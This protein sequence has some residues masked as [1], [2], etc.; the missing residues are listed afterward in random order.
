MASLKYMCI[1]TVSNKLYSKKFNIFTAEEN[2]TYY[3]ILKQQV[4]RPL[5]PFKTL[6][7][8]AFFVNTRNVLKMNDDGTH[9]RTGNFPFFALKSDPETGKGARKLYLFSVPDPLNLYTL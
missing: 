7:W 4:S 3:T 1:S 2:N 9:P 5:K 8:L 6:K